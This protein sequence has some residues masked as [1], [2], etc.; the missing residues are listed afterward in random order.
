M[1]FSVGLIAILCI[2]LAEPHGYLKS[3]IARSSIQLRPDFPTSGPYYWDHQAVWCGNVQ[4]D[5]SYS[6]CGRCGDVRGEITFNQGGYYDKGIIVASYTSGSIIE[7]VSE[8]GASHYGQFHYELCPSTVETDN[9]FQLL[10]IVGGSEQVMPNN[11]MCTPYD[12]SQTRPITT[13]LQLPAGVRC[14]RC[15]L[16]WTYRTFYPGSSDWN[17]CGLDQR[18][19]Q[20]FRNCAD[21]SIN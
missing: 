17:V 15:T 18:P 10:T 16:R 4:Q 8:F 9:C 14:T 12:N 21:I 3:P 7:V 5:L 11:R 6:T 13:R 1:L 20:T 2:G 19:A